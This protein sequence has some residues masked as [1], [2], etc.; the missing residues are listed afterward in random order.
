MAARDLKQSAWT[1]SDRSDIAC[2]NGPTG[3]HPRRPAL[4]WHEGIM[5][6]SLLYHVANCDGGNLMP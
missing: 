2:R 5:I 1:R 3:H 6:Q 4:V